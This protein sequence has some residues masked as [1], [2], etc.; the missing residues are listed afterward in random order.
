MLF[1]TDIDTPSVSQSLSRLLEGQN[2]NYGVVYDLSG[3]KVTTLMIFG[4]AP[5]VGAAPGST[6]SGSRPQPFATPRTSKNEP[7]PEEDEVE[8][9]P[10][11]EPVPQATPVI[12]PPSGR[13]GGPGS[14]TSPFP[15]SPFTPRSPFGNPL[16]TRPTPPPVPSPS[17]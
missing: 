14:P 2:L 10:E 4:L 8:E 17:P 11:P 6:A 7:P 5:K 15:P 1:N 9:V 13:P 3:K 12:A 16:A